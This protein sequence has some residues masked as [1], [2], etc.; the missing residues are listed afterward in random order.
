MEVS[1]VIR[2]E[3]RDHLLVALRHPLERVVF[4]AVLNPPP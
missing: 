2:F 3:G 1:F 4:E